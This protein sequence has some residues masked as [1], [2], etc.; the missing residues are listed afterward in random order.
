MPFSSIIGHERP[1]S[2]LKRAIANNALAHAYLFSGEPGIGKAMTA[3]ALAEA[4][5]CQAPQPEGGCGVCPSCHKV[6]ARSHPD[7]HVLAPDGTEIKIDQVREAQS[8]L[9]LRPF[10][11]RRK[12]LI[13]DNAD[14]LNEAASN[15]FLKTLE[16]PPG[17][18]LIILITAMP[19]SLLVTIRSRCQELKFQPL[20]RTVVAEALQQQRSLD[21]DDAWFLAALSRGSLGS[22]LSMDVAEE[23]ENREQVARMLAS[24]PGLRQDDVLALAEG[25]AKD[26]DGFAQIIDL[27]VER[28]RDILVLL[29][30]GDPHLQTFPVD[31]PAGGTGRARILKDLALFIASR[32]LLARRVSAQLVAENLFL[33][34]RSG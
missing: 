10:E 28:L 25:I 11:G 18:S 22:A 5:N 12:V 6:G 30:T 13:V 1:L 23:K 16:E 20:P 7:L 21:K 2:I 14:G 24:L 32:D 29:E 19:Q 9:A 17:E 26:R 8:N 4:L 3:Y 34:L 15:A 31:A 33:G 27:G